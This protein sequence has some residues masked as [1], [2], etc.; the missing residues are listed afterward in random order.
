MLSGI[1]ME[2]TFG[3]DGSVRALSTLSRSCLRGLQQASIS[4]S[5][6]DLRRLDAAKQYE[7]PLHGSMC[8]LRDASQR[9]TPAYLS[10]M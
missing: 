8:D 9:V 7:P 1:S 2:T 10:N 4:R 5:T 6:L 3:V